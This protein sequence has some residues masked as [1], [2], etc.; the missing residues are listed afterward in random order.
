MLAAITQS[1]V[2]VFLT[3]QMPTAAPAEI[4]RA[5][6]ALVLIL[7]LAGTAP[8]P[9]VKPAPKKPR[10]YREKSIAESQKLKR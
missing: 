7:K 5:S 9:A 2:R 10:Q 4:E 8:A 3:E 1:E 6:S